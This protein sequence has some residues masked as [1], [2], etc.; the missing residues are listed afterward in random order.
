M[1]KSFF[2][3]IILFP[4]KLLSLEVKCDFEEVYSDGSIQQGFF[5]LKE[6]KLRYEYYDKNLFTIFYKNDEFFIVNKSDKSN[7][8]KILSN[9]DHIKELINIS[10]S[11]P[12]IE[13]EYFK[14]N[15]KIS[16]EENDIGF[17]KRISIIAENLALSIYLNNCNFEKYHNRFYNYSPYFDYF[18]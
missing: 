18:D 2:I 3:F 5:L 10:T 17:Y 4:I 12:N 6:K 14:E 16:L 9:T 15:L 8:Q 7:F 1:N 13:K 11:Y